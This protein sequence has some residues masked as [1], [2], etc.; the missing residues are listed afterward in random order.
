MSR[1]DI[2]KFIT[3]LKRSLTVQKQ[4]VLIATSLLALLFTSFSYAKPP[5]PSICPTVAA[6]SSLGV[7]RTTLAINSL[8]FAGRRNQKYGTA[9]N[10]TFIVGDI[11]AVDVNDAFLKATSSL[12]S[13]FLQA[14][15]F[16]DSEFDRWLCIYGNAKGYPSI[17]FNPPLVGM[18]A[19]IAQYM[20]KY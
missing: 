3:N 7:S 20:H 6:L 2:R 16:F 13:L 1:L 9:N 15:P 12:P 8:W 19:S 4:I 11:P 10:W 5:Q 14:G 18:D 17:A